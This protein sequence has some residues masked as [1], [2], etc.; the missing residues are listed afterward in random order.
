M[1]SR[2]LKIV[3]LIIGRGRWDGGRAQGMG[4][5]STRAPPVD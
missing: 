2:M 5:G 1:A 3:H 4:S